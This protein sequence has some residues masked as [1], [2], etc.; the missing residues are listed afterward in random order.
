LITS[1]EGCDYAL[2]DQYLCRS[3]P[4]RWSR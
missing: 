4:P 3:S 2:P 1:L